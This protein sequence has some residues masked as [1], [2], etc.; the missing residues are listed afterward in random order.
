MAV[1]TNK[2]RAVIR[3]G[4]IAGDDFEATL[5]ATEG[6]EAKDLSGQ[7]FTAQVR[8]AP[9]SDTLTATFSV[10]ATDAATGVLVVSLANSVTDAIPPGEYAWDLR[11][12]DGDDKVKTIMAGTLDVVA[13]VTELG[14]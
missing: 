6:G 5:T 9:G 4:L 1:T 13:P 10:D 11:G 14:A 3:L 12:V 7:T 2:L 8:P